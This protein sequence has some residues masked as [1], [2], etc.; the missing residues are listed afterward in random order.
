M[1]QSLPLW[2]R[3]SVSYLMSTVLFVGSYL[4]AR[5]LL[6]A[7]ISSPFNILAALLPVP[8]AFLWISKFIQHI[9][10]LDELQRRIYLEALAVAFPLT[11]LLLL[12]LGLLELTI[13]L[14]AEDWSYRHVWAMLPLLYFVGLALA[15]RRYE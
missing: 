7:N 13:N 8:F 14:P 1:K 2:Q 10:Q 5:L 6:R 15:K 9:R 12:T 11:F 4:L 3:F